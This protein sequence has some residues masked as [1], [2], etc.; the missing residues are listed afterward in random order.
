[1]AKS[2]AG[3][4]DLD[5]ESLSDEQVEDI[6]KKAE[7][8]QKDRFNKRVEEL[9]PIALKAGYRVELTPIGQP[10][11]EESQEEHRRHRR[12]TDEEGKKDERRRVVI[13]KFQN[14]DN[15]SELWTA[16]GMEP[17]WLKDKQ[18]Q[19]HQ[20]SAFLIHYRNPDNPSETWAWEGE[21]SKTPKWLLEK[22]DQGLDLLQFAIPPAERSG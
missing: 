12:P 1:M 3:I 4:D 15:P 16:R 21:G 17:K 5:F 18:A 6:I 9:R 2:P 20:K 14:P 13:P 22:V 10:G 19:G 11:L 7:E 8:V